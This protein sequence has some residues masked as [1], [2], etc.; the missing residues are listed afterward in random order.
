MEFCRK[1]SEMPD[2]KTSGVTYRLPTEAEWEY[3]C[4]AGTTTRYSF[5]DSSALSGEFAWSREN[6]DGR[7]HPV[8]KKKPN[9]W[10]LYD[11]H[12]NAYEWCQDWY[13]S[14]PSG[15]VKDPR[16]PESGSLR[17]TRGGS[18]NY[19]FVN[20][21][22]A[23]RGRTT[24]I[25]RGFNLGFRVVRSS[26]QPATGGGNVNGIST[27]EKSMSKTTEQPTPVSS[28]KKPALLFAP[29][30]K[31]EAKAEQAA[32]ARYLKTD[33][34]KTNSIGMKLMLVPPGEFLM[35]SPQSETARGKN[36]RQHRVQLIN[37]FY[38]GTTEVT[39]LQWRTVMGTEPW[40]GVAS[41][42]PHFPD[43][44]LR[45]GMRFAPD[46][47]KQ[48]YSAKSCHGDRGTQWVTRKRTICG[49]VL[50]AA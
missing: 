20:C 1:L 22:S 24:P 26:S 38:L 41:V 40:K 15:E 35:G 39:Q 49:S 21:L 30:S 43:D 28:P 12:G 16:G 4:R 36:E 44:F 32:W 31:Q 48:G 8:G 11:M 18:W 19:T 6:S 2:S 9:P 14:Y 29:F 42:N 47:L 27:T 46:P 17:V 3:A 5:G 25:D 34:I 33:V 23:Y 50:T 13:G 7:T 37:R 45:F 10:G